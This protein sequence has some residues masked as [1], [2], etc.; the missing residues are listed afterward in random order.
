MY[1][2]TEQGRRRQNERRHSIIEATQRLVSQHGLGGVSVQAVAAEA[3]VATGTVYRYF[4]S[5]DALTAEVLEAICRRELHLVAAIVDTPDLSATQR[6]A[7]A[8]ACFGRRTLA[9]GRTAYSVIAEPSVA[10]VEQLRTDLRRD[11]A[12]TFA[13]V[14]ADGVASGEF[15]V[16]VPDV[17]G[18]A[19]VGAVSEVLVGP[20]GARPLDVEGRTAAVVDD[21]VALVLRMVGSAT[22]HVEPSPLVGIGRSAAVAGSAGGER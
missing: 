13:S 22:P 12:S 3:G 4:D 19:I 21:V 11:L 5:K 15:D 9:G 17:A 7:D 14:V 2:H 1:R 10:S 6:L 18:V 20:V 16:A 8:V